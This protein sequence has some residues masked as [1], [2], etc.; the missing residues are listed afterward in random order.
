VPQTL[1]QKLESKG[2]HQ[3]DIRRPRLQPSVPGR[4]GFS[5]LCGGKRITAESHEL[6]WAGTVRIIP[7]ASFVHD[8]SSQL[9][10]PLMVTK[11]MTTEP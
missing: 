5:Q 3:R 7:R 2:Q 6:V 9:L 4:V 1:S 11:R 10:L 8:P